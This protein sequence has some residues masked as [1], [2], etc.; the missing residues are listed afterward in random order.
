MARRLDAGCDDGRWLLSQCEERGLEGIGSK[1]RD[2]PYSSGKQ[3][4]WV[5]VK[6]HAWREANRDRHRLFERG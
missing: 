3:S 2:S 5:K 6:C 1:Q 4:N